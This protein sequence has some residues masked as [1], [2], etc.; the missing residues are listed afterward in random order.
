MRFFNTYYYDGFFFGNRVF[1][2]NLDSDIDKVGSES[3]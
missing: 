2:S 1:I 3:G